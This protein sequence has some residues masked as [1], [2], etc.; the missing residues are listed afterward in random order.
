MI[1]TSKVAKGLIMRF[2]RKTQKAIKE[3]NTMRKEATAEGLMHLGPTPLSEFVCESCAIIRG[4]FDKLLGAE[5]ER[6][7]AMFGHFY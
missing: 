4:E 1:V 5:S 2:M 6:D 3:Y 7:P